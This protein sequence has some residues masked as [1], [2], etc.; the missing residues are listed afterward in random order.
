MAQFHFLL[1][2]SLTLLLLKILS[3]VVSL[4]I[5][6][7]QSLP[8]LHLLRRQLLN[9]KTRTSNKLFGVVSILALAIG[10]ISFLSHTVGDLCLLFVEENE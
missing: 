5:I 7:H 4:S 8:L 10:G 2:N 1:I 9:Q 6:V 3:Y